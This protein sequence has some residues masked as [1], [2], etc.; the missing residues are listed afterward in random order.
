MREADL[1]LCAALTEGAIS[2]AT[3]QKSPSF[4][5]W[6]NF[7]LFSNHITTE[8]QGRNETLKLSPRNI[9]EK[10]GW[11]GIDIPYELDYKISLSQ[12][13]RN[14]QSLPLAQNETYPVKTLSKFLWSYKLKLLSCA[15]S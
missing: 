6:G 12:S 2:A 14:S 9:L 8:I 4:L 5:D 7:E 1:L 3:Y 13:L 10:L 11:K 15:L